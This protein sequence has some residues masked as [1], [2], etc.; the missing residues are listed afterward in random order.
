MFESWRWFLVQSQSQSQSQF[1]CFYFFF[2]YQFLRTFTLF[3]TRFIYWTIEFLEMLVTASHRTKNR[4]TYENPVICRPR[5]WTDRTLSG[6]QSA[7]KTV[8]MDRFGPHVNGIRNWQNLVRNAHS[9]SLLLLVSSH[10]QLLTRW[11]NWF[12]FI[13]GPSGQYVRTTGRKQH[14]WSEGSRLW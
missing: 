8:V 1:R 5:P 2:G 12:L 6:G 14:F 3:I 4:T 11:S 9:F 10:F 7:V 13:S